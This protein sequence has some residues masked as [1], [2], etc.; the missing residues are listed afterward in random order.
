MDDHKVFFAG[1]TCRSRASIV[2][3]ALAVACLP[4]CFVSDEA[5][6]SERIAAFPIRGD[7]IV[8]VIDRSEQG[9]ETIKETY[10]VSQE[11]G[12]YV[13]RTGG[14]VSFSARLARIGDSRQYIAMLKMPGRRD[15]GYG[16]AERGS[17]GFRV[18]SFRLNDFEEFQRK[19]LVLAPVGVEKDGEL[20]VRSLRTL[21]DLFPKMAAAGTFSSE[22]VY[23]VVPSDSAPSSAAAGGADGKPMPRGAWQ[24]SNMKDPMTDA[25]IP[26]ARLRAGRVDGARQGVLLQLECQ[27]REPVV[28]L[29]WTGVALRTLFRPGGIDITDIDVRFD[30]AQPKRLVWAIVG[31]GQV[32]NP[33]PQAGAVIQLGLNIDATL[34]PSRRGLDARWAY[35]DFA[36]PLSSSRRLI[37]Q[38]RS[39]G[40]RSMTAFFDTV[41]AAAAVNHLRRACP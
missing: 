3:L 4:G 40:N 29:D 17:D 30:D 24:I 12:F 38:A 33:P 2:G 39:S 16:L 10:A 20:S 15:L 14:K 34:I 21:M 36:R 37:V 28:F 23:R 35:D 11:S 25:V 13:F 27:D 1:S 41:G 32:R 9:A 22:T 8:Q 31:D 5:L 19:H 18:L 7:V 6:I 26:V